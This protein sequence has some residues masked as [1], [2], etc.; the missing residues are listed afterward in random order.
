MER[1]AKTD[2]TGRTPR[3]IWVFAG[4]TCHFVGFVIS[5]LSFLFSY[6]VLTS[7]C[8]KGGPMAEW[9]RRVIFS[10]LNHCHLT[11]V[12]S[13]LARVTRDKPSGQ[14]SP[15]FAPPYDLLAQNDQNNEIIR[16]SNPYQRKKICKKFCL[17]YMY[18]IYSNNAIY[19]SYVMRWN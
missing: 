8:K 2:Q 15:V 7:S 18:R 14:V 17:Q 5:R 19:K 3:L 6:I 1:T 4:R 16:L 13:S 10:T 11:T 12:G 9:L